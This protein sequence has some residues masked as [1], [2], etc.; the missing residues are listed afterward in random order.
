MSLL[1]AAG[2][3]GIQRHPNA[4]IM[5][6][7]PPG[8]PE[9]N[10]V[11]SAET[12]HFDYPGSD[13]I[14]RSNDS[15]D[16]RVLKLYITNVSPIL[17]EKLKDQFQTT[18]NS[19]EAT[20]GE[21]ALPVLKLT[22]TGA[23][24]FSLLTFIFPATPAPILPSATENVMKLL[25]VAQKYQMDSVLTH[26]RG[27]ISLRD[28]QFIR[29]E[30]AFHHYALAQDHELLQEAARAARAT[31]RFSLTIESLEGMIEFM[32]GTYL[33]QL[34]KFHE[35]VR[36]DLKPVLR[37][38]RN[39]GLPD[40]VKGLQCVTYSPPSPPGEPNS[41]PLPQWLHE[42]IESIAQAPHVP[43]L[44]EFEN[45]RA[46]HIVA[47]NSYST[48]RCAGISSQA[49]RAFGER[50]TAVIDE[51]IKKVREPVWIGSSR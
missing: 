24:I 18:P 23:I 50:L 30:I 31:L 42:Y 34:S 32:P 16:F 44:F 3:I 6:V 48:C 38:F 15:Y 4:D 5:S 21:E 47:Q 40:G 7:F 46:R 20:H 36:T 13:L 43:D 10:E 8:T 51:T 2:S 25:S 45:A 28:P 29:P 12:L 19:P 35:R 41:V 27:I 14:L 17:R 22:E 9:P 26:I 11:I 39:T 49:I 1:K 33:R 37:E